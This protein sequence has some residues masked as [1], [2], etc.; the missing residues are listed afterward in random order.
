MLIDNLQGTLVGWGW[1][2]IKRHL[3]ETPFEAIVFNGGGRLPS[4]LLLHSLFELV[5]LVPQDKK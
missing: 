1:V 4:L 3:I 2:L 5:T